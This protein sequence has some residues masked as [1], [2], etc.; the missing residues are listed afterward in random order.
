MSVRW[1]LLFNGGY[2]MFTIAETEKTV[3]HFRL[4]SLADIHGTNHCW[5]MGKLYLFA[6]KAT[7]HPVPNIKKHCKCK[8]FHQRTIGVVTIVLTRSV[9]DCSDFTD[10]YLHENLE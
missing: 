5:V 7:R 6:G 8:G 10:I 3:R 9:M 1:Q 2:F 4:C